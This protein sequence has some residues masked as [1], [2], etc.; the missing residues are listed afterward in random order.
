MGDYFS[1]D[2]SSCGDKKPEV[3][4]AYSVEILKDLETIIV[5]VKKSC[6]CLVLNSESE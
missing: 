6:N 5:V 2:S 3:L 1:G 4:G